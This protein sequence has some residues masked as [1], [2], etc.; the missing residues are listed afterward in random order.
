MHLVPVI[1]SIPAI[2]FE[3]RGA[4]LRVGKVAFCELPERDQAIEGVVPKGYA[5][6]AHDGVA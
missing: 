5:V 3:D 6:R 2:L 1:V 4:E